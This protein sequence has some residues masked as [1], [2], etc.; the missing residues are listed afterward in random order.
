M[1]FKASLES[2]ERKILRY[3]VTRGHVLVA[4]QN[5]IQIQNLISIAK[6]NA[7]LS[8]RTTYFFSFS[9]E[10]RE[11]SSESWMRRIPATQPSTK[12]MQTYE[13]TIECVKP[14]DEYFPTSQFEARDWS[15]ASWPWYARDSSGGD[16]RNTRHPRPNESVR[17]HVSFLHDFPSEDD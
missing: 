6:K 17:V 11:I 2:D 4:W 10:K 8:S 3:S 16:S 9:F 7:V 14:R 15:E 12:R 1:K 13:T 5:P